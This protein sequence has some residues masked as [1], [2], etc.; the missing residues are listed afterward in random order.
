MWIPSS[1]TGPVNLARAQPHRAMTRLPWGCTYRAPPLFLSR[2]P[3]HSHSPST[4]PSR[5]PS[6]SYDVSHHPPARSAPKKPRV[7]LPTCPCSVHP[8]LVPP[9]VSPLLQVLLRAPAPSLL[10]LHSQNFQFCLLYEP[11][12]ALKRRLSRSHILLPS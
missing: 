8:I 10:S 9:T 3:H 12:N 4:T 5:S 1:A 7:K 6:L 2:Y 11:S